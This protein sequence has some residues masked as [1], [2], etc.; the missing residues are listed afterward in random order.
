MNHADPCAVVWFRRSLRLDDNRALVAAHATGLPILCLFVLDPAILGHADM[1]PVRVRFL[2]QGL[3]SLARQLEQVGGRL[4]VRTGDPEGILDDLVRNYGVRAVFHHGETEPWGRARD[5]RV[6]R[7][8]ASRGVSCVPVDDHLVAAPGTVL[9][10]KGTPFGVF[11]AFRKVWEAL[12][13]S[14]PAGL[15]SNISWVTS[16]ASEPLP[17]VPQAPDWWV[18]AGEHGARDQWERF[19]VGP[20]A[21]YGS[22]RDIPSLDGTSGL[23]PH[24]KF[25]MV[26]ARRLVADCR[27]IVAATGSETTAASVRTFVSE[28]CWRDFYHHILHFFPHVEDGCYQARF[29]ALMWENEA[30][31]FEAWIQGRTGYPFVDAAM[32]QLSA[33]GWMHNRARM[34]VASFLTKD[35]LIDWRWGERHFRRLLVDGDLAPNNGGWQWAAGTGTDAQPWFRIFNPVSQ[36]TRFDPDGHYVRRWV[37]ELAKVPAAGIHSPWTMSALELAHCGVRLGID[38][39]RPVVDHGERRLRALA[40]FKACTGSGEAQ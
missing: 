4:V 23:S 33:T 26:S 37:P 31:L 18:C 22:D 2:L 3:D 13:M 8:L 24:L 38:Y 32:R 1:A 21:A 11:T 36:G 15:P 14:P 30:R 39:P 7:T 34:V 20:L 5:A 29:D 35:L 28:L 9:T 6:A 27:D 12:P 10:G 25:G 19:R 40:M 16:L 17:A